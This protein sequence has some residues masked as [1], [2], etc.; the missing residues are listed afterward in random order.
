M[1]HRSSQYEHEEISRARWAVA[2]VFF[3]N[4]FVL[5][6]WVARVPKVAARVRV[7]PGALSLALLAL[8]LAAGA[9]TARADS[10]RRALLA[11]A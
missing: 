6:V 10:A 4:G 1:R 2:A 3:L 8:A 9:L 5:A 7:G 11:G